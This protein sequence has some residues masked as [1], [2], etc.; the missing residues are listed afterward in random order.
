[1]AEN[2]DPEESDIALSHLAACI[3]R[4]EHDFRECAEYTEDG[5]SYDLLKGEV[6][7]EALPEE[8]EEDGEKKAK[9]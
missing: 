9:G 4:L 7:E 3:V 5:Q 8:N 1:M 2:A 6:I